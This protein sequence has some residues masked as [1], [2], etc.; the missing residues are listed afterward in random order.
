MKT[1]GDALVLT[2]CILLAMCLAGPAAEQVDRVLR[3]H[4]LHSTILQ[5]VMAPWSL[6]SFLDYALGVWLA[7]IFSLSVLFVLFSREVQAWKKALLGFACL[8]I[9]PILLPFIERTKHLW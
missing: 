6:M 7:A 5:V 1:R 9:W 4:P 8:A 3:Y 2:S